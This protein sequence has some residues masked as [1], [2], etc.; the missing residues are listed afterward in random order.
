M[1]PIQVIYQQECI[2][3][4]KIIL[5]PEGMFLKAYEHSAFLLSVNVKAFKPS[6]RVFKSLGE[7]VVSVG[8]P[9]GSFEK[10]MKGF[11]FI[12][13]TGGEYICDS[14]IKFDFPAFVTWKNQLPLKSDVPKPS[15]EGE[16][17]KVYVD[18]YSLLIEIFDLLVNVPKDFKRTL[19]PEIEK[20]MLVIVKSVSLAN[21]SK[22]SLQRIGHI[23]D[24]VDRA[25]NIK[26]LIRILSDLR[27][28]PVKRY[29]TLS[30]K[31]VSIISQLVGWKKY[32]EQKR[33][34]ESPLSQV[35]T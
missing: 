1:G 33:E 20:D 17:I 14:P 29:M 25:E 34:E 10:Y 35:K 5:R 7:E 21:G 4:D 27:A 28:I 8:F 12:V 3:T 32:I 19:V 15:S 30:D 13:G 2:N 18:A 24:A 22:D 16:R 26:L 23:S 6:K 11:E 9:K 31:L